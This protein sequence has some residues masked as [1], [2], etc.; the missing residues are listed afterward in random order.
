MSGWMAVRAVRDPP[1]RP[2]HNAGASVIHDCARAL[3]MVRRYRAVS[4]RITCSRSGRNQCAG[5]MI[6]C[7]P[8]CSRSSRTSN[9]RMPSGISQPFLLRSPGR[10]KGDAGSD[11]HEDQFPRRGVASRFARPSAD[12]RARCVKELLGSSSENNIFLKIPSP[13]SVRDGFKPCL[14]TAHFFTDVL[15]YLFLVFIQAF[16]GW[17]R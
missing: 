12:A 6:G 14:A 9:M 11:A 16:F 13:E 1:A 15:R 4:T 3:R 17:K 8:I 5:R 7:G 10:G 2:A